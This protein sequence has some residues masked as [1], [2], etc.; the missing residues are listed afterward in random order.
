M[1]GYGPWVLEFA[2]EITGKL[3]KMDSD[4]HFWMPMTLSKEAYCE[5]MAGEG[6][7]D[8][9]GGALPPLAALH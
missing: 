2:G 6:G 1:K 3:A 4:P 9:P 7:L 8:T 5:V